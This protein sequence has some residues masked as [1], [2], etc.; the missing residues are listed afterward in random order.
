MIRLGAKI[1]CG[2]MKSVAAT[3]NLDSGSRSAWPE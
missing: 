3:M 1:Y 2:L